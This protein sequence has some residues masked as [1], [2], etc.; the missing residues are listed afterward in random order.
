MLG[1]C[2]RSLPW[3]A[4]QKDELFSGLIVTALGSP[5]RVAW[6]NSSSPGGSGGADR[7]GA[8]GRGRGIRLDD[9]ALGAD[10]D[11]GLNVGTVG[12]RSM[13]LH[14]VVLSWCR[15]ALSGNVSTVGEM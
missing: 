10:G 9:G 13:H 2:V 5:V 7:G 14:G 1:L 11:D 15:C 3:I 4:V 6:E 8:G 12:G